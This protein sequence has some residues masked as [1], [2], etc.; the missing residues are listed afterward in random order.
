[1]GVTVTGLADFR[2]RM[3]TTVRGY[4]P[5]NWLEL[6]ILTA[7][8]KGFK[9]LSLEVMCPS[10]LTS[11]PML[12]AEGDIIDFVTPDILKPNLS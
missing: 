6:L 5:P 4:I 2:K 10:D 12:G 7:E 11:F 8:Q 3:N 1:M 9:T